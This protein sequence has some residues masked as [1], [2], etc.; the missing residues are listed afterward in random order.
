[1]NLDDLLRDT[2]TDDRWALPVPADTLS[3]VRR[4]RVLRKRTRVL[5]AALAS[6][7]AVG[8]GA[9]AM[10]QS[11]GEQRSTLLPAAVPFSGCDVAPPAQ[12]LPGSNPAYVVSSARDWFLTKEQSAAFFDSYRQPSPAPGDSVPSPQATGPGT[13]RLVAIL[14]A[15]GV[16]GADALDRDEADSGDRGSPSLHGHLADGRELNVYRRILRFPLNRNGIGMDGSERLTTVEDVPGTACASLVF[17]GIPDQQGGGFA[18]TVAPDG[19]ITTWNSPQVSL[20]QLKTWAY[21][22]AQWETTHPV[23]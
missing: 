16:P 7:L 11:G 5:G 12:P 1:M 14:T 6:T 18:A 9:I 2:L 22:A 19:T 20:A 13:D 4:R 15:V 23:G 8:A 3:A 10:T 17:T 21:A